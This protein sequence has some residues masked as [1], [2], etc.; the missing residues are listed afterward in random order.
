VSIVETRVSVWEALAGRAP[1]VPTGPADRGLWN[2][3]AERIN[4]VR[5]RP[6]LRAGIESAELVSARGVPYVMLR[7]PDARS[8]C[9]LR[10]TPEEV[11]L[12][13]LM[14]GARTL[15]RL[16]AEFARIT[17]RL[18]PDQVRRV[19]AD[20]AGNRML[21]ELPV[22]AFRPLQRM[23]RRAWP[24]RFGRGLV[25]FV[26]G[27]R[28]VLANVD[29]LV[30]VLYKAGGRL[31]FTKVVATVLAA[32][33]VVG[34]AAFAWQ[35]WTGT[36]SVFL[37]SD[38]YFAGAAVL[39]GLNIVALACHELG[40][41]LAA[42]HAGRRVPS[43][44][45]LVYF[46]IPSVFVDTTDVW[47]AGRRARLRTT[48]AG[49]SA[50]LVLAGGAALVGLAVP[51]AA[52]WCFKL[53]FAWYLNAL[54]NLNP[55]LAL[56][57]YYVVMDWLELPNLRARGLAWVVAR[58]R[59][60]PPSW[61][62]L[63]REGRLVALYGL[64]AV[65]WLVIALNLGFRV[66]VDRVAGLSTGLWRSG[67]AAR[68]LLIV[69]V[70]ALVSPVVYLVAGWSGKRWRRL[71]EA[72]AEGHHTRDLP[73]RLDALRASSLRELP[74]AT[75]STLAERAHWVHPRTGQQLVFAGA[76]QPDVYAIVDGALEGRAPGDPVGTVR[77]RVGPGGIVGLAPALTGAPSPLAWYTAGTT[78]LAVPAS[79]VA[80]ALGPA[81]GAL[82]NP[83][84]STAE[85]EQ[86]LAASPGLAAL[87]TEDTLGLATVAVPISLAPGASISLR[88]PDEV[89]VLA[90]GVITTPNG[91]ELGRGTMIGP[92]G[93]E[94][95]PPVATARTPVRL[96]SVPAIS[97]LPLLLGGSAGAGRDT[98]AQTVNRAP[99]TGVHPPTAYPPLAG[100][101]GPPPTV[102]DDTDRRF[103]R[104]LRWLLL[105]VLL[106]AL[107]FTGGN[108]WLGTLAWAEMPSDAALLHAQRGPTTAV[109]N[110][111]PIQL[112]Q[113]QDLYV[114]QND[115]ITVP[116][117]SRAT[118]TYHGGAVS[119]LCANTNLALQRL[120]TLTNPPAPSASFTLHTGL[121]LTDTTSTSPAFQPLVAIIDLNNGP[122]TNTAAAW[123]ATAPD[124]LLVSDGQVQYAGFPIEATHQQLGCGDGDGVVPRPVAAPTT[125][126]S[127]VDTT[128][129]VTPTPT[130]TP[131]PATTT[132]Q[133]VAPPTSRSTKPA[134]SPTTTTPPLPPPVITIT[135]VSPTTVP[136]VDNTGQFICPTGQSQA[137]I[138]AT[139]TGASSINS[140]Y[141]ITSDGTKGTPAAEAAGNTLGLF[142]PSIQYVA[143]HTDPK[144]NTGSIVVTITAANSQGLSTSASATVT[145]LGCQPIPR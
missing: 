90:S 144:N 36:R 145:L 49:P 118:L 95:P 46:G 23:R 31:L 16:V 56:D 116:D 94:H 9:Y 140:F 79:S 61:R 102:D 136:E 74:L 97:G 86:V 62:M 65:G 60:R 78:L 3:V 10:L 45:F 87:S 134:P 132:T 12:T 142:L 50:G 139:I 54:F 81:G 105:L 67:W 44:G 39:L 88:G 143:S 25:A 84:G 47:M 82:I 53:A 104:T 37:T 107:L 30:T 35:W 103:E 127:T 98:M 96:F 19:V 100:P 120:V 114:R 20:L 108:L 40:H 48:I 59:R 111:H 7:S 80:A 124:S 29:P 131:T 1:G 26:R 126:P 106:L 43:A 72:I 133:V 109:V 70:A 93:V 68:V 101:P 69:V 138:T 2:A 110:G 119:V 13:R 52:P 21:E 18:A 24:L 141:T 112:A 117:R 125:S 15:A 27:R 55:F 28:V 130:D 11:Q 129:P 32:V 121:V 66:Y 8:S 22:D 85:A 99:T 135:S 123:F 73:R 33:A 92:A 51:A 71:R 128:P 14:D 64:L 5:A 42:K 113:G 34:L 122:V 6:V 115:T 17:G 63:D 77:E 4:P 57:G 89:L 58:L 38:S 137:T 83:H 76:A 91:T 75:L 41:A